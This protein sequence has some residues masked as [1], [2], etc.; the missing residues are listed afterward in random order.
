MTTSAAGDDAA[1]DRIAPAAAVRSTGDPSAA[2]DTLE[3]DDGRVGEGTTAS[4]PS[5]T[6]STAATRYERRSAWLG[7]LLWV[8]PP[9]GL[10][11]ITTGFFPG[12][13]PAK[14]SW[15]LGAGQIECLNTMGFAAFRSYCTQIGAPVGSPLLSGAPQT[16]LGLLLSYLPLIDAW[17]AYLIVGVL[18]VAGSYLAGVAVLRRF[19][20]PTWLASLGTFV[21]LTSSTVLALNGFVYTFHG[22]VMLPAATWAVFT[23]LE[24]F[25]RGRYVSAALIAFA[26]AWLMAFTDGYAFVASTVMILGIGL[27]WLLGDTA[28]RKK[29]AG[30]I[31]WAVA[32]ATGSLAYLSYIPPGGAHPQASMGSFRYLGADLLTFFIPSPSSYWASGMPWNG[33]LQRLWGTGDNQL[34]NYLGYVALG[35][36]VTLVLLGALR[37]GAPHRGQLWSLVGVGVVCAILSL[38]P[39]LKFANFADIPIKPGNLPAGETRF[40][41]PTAFLYEHVPGFQDMRATYRSFTVTRWALVVLAVVGLVMVLR[42]RARMLVPFLAILL[43]LDSVPNLAKQISN[44]QLSRA[45]LEVTRADFGIHLTQMIGPGD[46]A[47]ILPNANDFLA[48]GFVPFTGGSSYNVGIDK[49]VAYSM[50]SWPAPVRLAARTYGTAKFADN[51]C[52]LLHSDASVI[53]LSYL[54]LRA[55]AVNAAVT[56]GPDPALVQRA[57]DVARLDRFATTETPSGIALRLRPDQDCTA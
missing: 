45:Q 13:S 5:E 36:A 6:G 25:R 15:M 31:V 51:A 24:R 30:G 17:R 52:A 44:R 34:G 56:P 29:L 18:T 55:G 11:L 23:S 3:H 10:T 21:Y 54:D 47:L 53:V 12:F 7:N 2:V 32:L 4:S 50:A 20:A 39:N 48:S 9:L 37:R 1:G 8:V 16:Y 49:N 40:T 28:G 33:V 46:K 38:G 19:G 26:C 14:L 22:F 43:V 42:T 41:L 57:K 27:G 35:L